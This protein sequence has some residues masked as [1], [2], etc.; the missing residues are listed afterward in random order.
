MLLAL[1]RA[2]VSLAHPRMLWLMVW[3]VLAALALWIVLAV[4]FW[5]EALH[6]VEVELGATGAVQWMLTF[7]PLAFVA[8]HLAW[9]ILVLAFIPLV[10]VTAVL[11]VAVF[12]MPAMVN[13]VSATSY[14]GLERR[15]GGTFAGSLWNG[16][17]AL[18]LFVLLAVITLPLWAIP[19]LWPVLPVLLFA[20][21]NQRVFRYDA[22]AEHA[23][24]DELHVLVAR[25]RGELFLLGVVIAVLGHVP[26][27]GFFV[28]VYGAL[29]FVHY[30]L[31]RLQAMRSEPIE[32]TAVRS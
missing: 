15:H 13:H 11:L 3:P 27:V 5:S 16:A 31:E 7:A 18:A 9:V 24:S 23:S 12:A 29:A 30:G 19:L 2:F 20:Y 28:P 10:L 22:L 17:V 6:W 1:T 4:L 26:V 8:A 25:H 14:P 32:G 21:L